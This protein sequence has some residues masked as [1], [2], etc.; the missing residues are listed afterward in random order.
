MPNS[1]FEQN[2]PGLF[3]ELEEKIKT[4][5]QDDAEYVAMVIEKGIAE[6]KILL[7]TGKPA[8]AEQKYV[9]TRILVER[10]EAQATIHAERRA[11]QLLWVELAYLVVL[12]FVGYF[13]HLNPNYW[14]WKGFTTS[15]SAATAWFGALGGVTIA[16][17]GLYSH[18]QARDFDPKFRLWYLCKPIIGAVFGWFVAFCLFD[19]AGCGSGDNGQCAKSSAA[20][21][22]CVSSGIQ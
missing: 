18:I 13:T 19:W 14:L 22:H 5:A 15:P 9:D 17:F 16:L 8:E 1:T 12:L 6:A 10:A 21:C 2:A 20:L 11:F 4:L 3:H 7:E